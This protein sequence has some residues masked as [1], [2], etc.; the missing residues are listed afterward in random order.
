FAPHPST[1][2]YEAW[3]ATIGIYLKGSANGE[4]EM[5]IVNIDAK[6]LGCSGGKVSCGR[7]DVVRLRAN[8]AMF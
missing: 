2:S 8:L 4:N 1:L 7:G 3:A 5:A 6:I